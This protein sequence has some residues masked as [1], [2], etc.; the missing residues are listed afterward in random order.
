MLR[1]FNRVARLAW[2][3]IKRSCFK[4]AL[5][6]YVAGRLFKIQRSAANFKY[7]SYL[8]SS[9]KGLESLFTIIF[10]VFHKIITEAVKETCKKIKPFLGGA[11]PFQDEYL[12]KHFEFSS[13]G[14]RRREC[15]E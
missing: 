14:S 9:L 11:V 10:L 8:H 3:R 15:D 13:I 1:L 12:S 4:N 7:K 2:K 6:R 5:D